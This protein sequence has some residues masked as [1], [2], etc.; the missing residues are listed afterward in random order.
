MRKTFLPSGRAQ[1]IAEASTPAVHAAG[2]YAHRHHSSAREQARR[3]RQR[4]R[5]R[6]PPVTE[7]AFA[8]ARVKVDEMMDAV[9]GPPKEQSG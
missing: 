1:R 3:L 2:G 9:F 6:L 8:A 4:E 5:Y 7:E